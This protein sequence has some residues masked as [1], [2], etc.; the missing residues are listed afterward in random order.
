VRQVVLLGAG[1][2]TLA[3]REPDLATRFRFVEIDHHDSQCWKLE[4]LRELGLT[5]AGV[6]YVPVDFSS[7]DLEKELGAAGVRMEQPTFFAWLG[8]TQYITDGA[9]MATLSLA[10]RHAAGSEIVFDVIVPF[11]DLSP[12]E[13]Q[14][15]SAARAASEDRGEPWISFYRPDEIAPRLL[16]L[17]FGSVQPLSAEDARRYHVGQPDGITPSR[18]WQLISA[19]V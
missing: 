17:G 19:A 13:L 11:C 9:A 1:L 7:Q 16:A 2:D 3:L 18:A 14:I 4:R 15:S 12:D 6:Q 10:S 5:T 8:V